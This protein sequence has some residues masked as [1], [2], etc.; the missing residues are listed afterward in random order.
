MVA[1]LEVS[2]RVQSHAG[3]V[4][5]LLNAR[6][7][8]STQ[9]QFLSEDPVFLGDPKQQMLTDPQSLNSYSY[10]NGNPIKQSDPSGRTSYEYIRSLDPNQAQYNLF[11]HAFVFVVPSPGEVL[12]PLYGNG[13]CIDTTRPFTI[14]AFPSGGK[15]TAQVNN[16]GD[17]RLATA[18]QSLYGTVGMRVNGPGMTDAQTDAAVVRSSDALSP[19][20][21]WYNPTAS[22]GASNSNN[23]NTS[24]MLPVLGR[25]QFTNVQTA[26]TSQLQRPAPGLGTTISQNTLSNISNSLQTIFGIIKTLLSNKTPTR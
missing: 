16:P 24:V 22:F 13:M 2:N 15:L 19:D 25:P 8:N 9:G 23:F 26:L 11:G 1:S 5:A 10:A 6:Y 18:K 21:G 7:Y 12:P 17:Y 20:Q 14:G 3:V 4:R